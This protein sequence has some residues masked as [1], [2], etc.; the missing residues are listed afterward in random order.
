[1]AGDVDVKSKTC[2]C[3]KV[4]SFGPRGGKR[5]HCSGCRVDGDVDLIHK[6]CTTCDEISASFAPPGRHPTR[7][8]GCR[9]RGDV[10]VHAR[11][12]SGC[13]K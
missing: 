9:L 2:G 3:G 1:V 11:M 4:P 5:V 10:S 12:C 6:L 13:P 7:C 8:A